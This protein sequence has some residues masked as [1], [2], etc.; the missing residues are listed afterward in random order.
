VF[1]SLQDGHCPLHRGASAPQDEQTNTVRALA[2][3]TI[4]NPEAAMLARVIPP[5]GPPGIAAQVAV[6]AISF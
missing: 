2:M 5:T 3:G 6:S 4:R 1:H